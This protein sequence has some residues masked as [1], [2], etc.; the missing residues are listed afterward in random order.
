V[1]LLGTCSSVDEVA[2]A[3][4]EVRVGEVIA[5]GFGFVP[6]FHYIVHDRSGRCIV[7]EYTD[8][9]LAIHD[10]PIGVM[11]NC[12]TFDW[13]LTNLRNYVNLTVTN[14]PKVELLGSKLA[15]LGQGPGMHGLPGD[16]TPPSRFVRAAVFSQSALPVATARDGVLQAFHILNQFDIP[17]GASREE[18]HGKEIAEYTLWTTAADL[19]NLRYYFHTF[20]SRRIRMIDLQTMDLDARDIRTIPMSGEEVIDDVSA[21]SS[22][23]EGASGATR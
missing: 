7:L 20:E 18:D 15:P 5:E 6:P 17:K 10:N 1:Y 19:S 9:R 22:R 21:K 2:Q 3:A 23:L 12:P 4:K 16:F 14:V 13:H 11:S 8:G